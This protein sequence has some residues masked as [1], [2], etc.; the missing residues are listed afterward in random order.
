MS[1][2]DQHVH[3]PQTAAGSDR[4]SIYAT[5]SPRSPRG[6]PS[7]HDG[8]AA[9]EG[10]Y[11]DARSHMSGRHS[12]TSHKSSAGSLRS[13]LHI[14]GR[15]SQSGAAPPGEPSLK[16]GKSHMSV[17]EEME[18]EDRLK[19][20]PTHILDTILEED[21]S[22]E[23]LGIDQAA[24]DLAFGGTP[25]QSSEHKPD[26]SAATSRRKGYRQNL[27]RRRK[28]RRFA[29]GSKVLDFLKSLY[30]DYMS[31]T[32][33]TRLFCWWFP[34]AAI[35]F[36]PLAVGAWQNP[37]MTLGSTRVMWI[38]IWLEVVWA[39]LLIGRV[40]AR[41]FP[42]VLAAII[43]VV[44][45]R[46]FKF[47]DLAFSLELAV[48]LVVWTFVSFITFGPLLHDNKDALRDDDGNMPKWQVI[49]QDILVAFLVSSLIFFC[50]QVFIHLLSVSF[51]RARMSIRIARSK[52]AIK[53]LTVLLGLSYH[54]F[55]YGCE[56][57][58]EEDEILESTGLQSV[59]NRT[60]KMAS[61]FKPLDVIN[62]LVHNSVDVT[63]QIMRT[64]QTPSISG[65]VKDAL[66]SKH[67]A[68]VLACRIWKSLVMEDSDS[69]SYE[70]LLE[71]IGRDRQEE[72]LFMFEI[73]DI[74][75]GS[76]I[77]LEEMIKSVQDI[78]RERKDISKSLVDM[79]GA[80]TK[81]HYLLLFLCL[82]IVIIIFVGMLAP[83]SATVLA[84]L[85]STILSMSFLFSSTASEVF[86]SCIFLF[87][88][89]P[90][91]VGDWVK[92]SV[93]GP[94]YVRMQVV[95]I[96][97]LHSTFSEV[98]SNIIRQCSNS[99]LN[100][101]FIDNL[102]RSG[103]SQVSTVLTLGLPETKMQDIHELIVR[104]SQFIDE[105]PRQFMQAPFVQITE[106]ADLDKISLTVCANTR[107][108]QDDIVL[109]SEVCTK[110]YNFLSRCINEIPLI[111][112]RR[113]DTSTDP[114]LPVYQVNLDHQISHKPTNDPRTVGLRRRGG[115]LPDDEQESTETPVPEV[116]PDTHQDKSP[117]ILSRSPSIARST[118][119]MASHLSRYNN[120]HGLRRTKASHN[121]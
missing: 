63:N 86:T 49:I 6:V 92:I 14:T 30:T 10:L 39:S 13:L 43:A 59:Q 19:D 55:P 104:I 5:R 98:G 95:K 66:A 38:F 72:V 56:E 75:G 17:K 84:T 50:E 120:A 116:L 21:P 85:G 42:E 89:H 102:S 9:E 29:Q 48:T 81:L 23:A 34:L 108:S 117:A 52:K 22:D 109:Y 71:A 61:K 37:D 110:F 53:V 40:V 113:D 83:S 1:S 90:Y 28:I 44:A 33:V 26:D 60:A 106:Q 67:C 121:L 80:I 103:G 88:K 99:V 57:F 24:T 74:D 96:A 46:Y 20:D 97:L 36:V 7:Y 105:N 15:R 76:T 35:L 64:K 4:E 68:E 114:A 93:A 25:G 12:Q 69:L 78:G 112:P 62:K 91:D 107:C 18:M 73:L 79:D 51:H 115:F 119:S 58:E 31:R 45:P 101:I 27:E 47:V 94:G 87:V 70:E 65:T 41:Y 118:T 8:P 2:H 32:L 77:D 3:P 16:S 111:I 54:Y 100:T 11:T 82:I